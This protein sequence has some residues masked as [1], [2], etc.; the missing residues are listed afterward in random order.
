ML[1][2][3]W[4]ISAAFLAWLPSPSGRIVRSGQHEA[5]FRV[6]PEMRDYTSSSPRSSAIFCYTLPLGRGGRQFLARTFAAA[7]RLAGDILIS[8]WAGSA[9]SPPVRPREPAVPA[10]STVLRNP[11]PAVFSRDTGRS[12]AMFLVRHPPS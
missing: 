1:T 11:F 8:P 6:L 12:C 5:A 7:V 3:C 4:T 10:C 2:P 9:N